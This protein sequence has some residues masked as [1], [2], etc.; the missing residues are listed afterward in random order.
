MKQSYTFK[1]ALLQSSYWM[2]ACFFYSFAQTF[3]SE[4]GL[5]KTE[6]GLVLALANIIAFLAQ[7]LLAAL[8]D[9]NKKVTFKK[10]I[11]TLS[12]IAIACSVGLYFNSPSLLVAILFVSLTTLTLIVQ[13]LV[14][15][16]GFAFIDRGERLNYSAARGIGSACYALISLLYGELA[17]INKDYLLI[18]FA[19]FGVGTIAV[20]LW[21]AP[22]SSAPEEQVRDRRTGGNIELLRAH[23]KLIFMLGGLVLIFTQHNLINAYLLSIVQR[24]GGNEGS[25]GLAC[26]IGAMFE[27]PIMLLYLKVQ[28]RFRVDRLIKWAAIMFTVKSAILLLPLGLIGVYI[29]QA[30]Q[31]LGYAIMIPAT[32]YYMNELVSATDKVKAQA[33]ITAAMVIAG[34]IGYQ[35]GGILMEWSVVGTLLVGTGISAVGSA[36]ML[37]STK[38]I[39]GSPA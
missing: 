29:S 17:Q 13:P 12:A 38:R 39:Q 32:G 18:G 3:L 1:Y 26:F 30:T 22:S 25:V 23:P 27:V 11:A 2:F 28:S 35:L 19:V 7:P 20:N 9:R 14:N 24:V 10:V 5:A 16:M 15:S 8:M 31:M 34:V 33:L 36:V 6:I 4:K 21:I 37:L